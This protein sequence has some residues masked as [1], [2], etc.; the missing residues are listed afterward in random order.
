MNRERNLKHKSRKHKKL[1]LGGGV[2]KAWRTLY[3]INPEKEHKRQAKWVKNI[4]VCNNY[5]EDEDMNDYLIGFDDQNDIID[6]ILEMMKN[7][8]RRKAGLLKYELDK[9]YPEQIEEHN[10]MIRKDIEEV[11]N[12][13]YRERRLHLKI[14]K[15]YE[16][17]FNSDPRLVSGG[18][19]KSR[20]YKQ[21]R[22]KRF[23]R[24]Y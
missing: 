10:D 19:P 9:R 6:I 11:I 18:K 22:R 8:C 17:L 23:T 15:D 16:F 24:K 2:Q 4:D 3:D 13:M 12:K 1:R 21:I 5:P 7:N 14:I 20:I